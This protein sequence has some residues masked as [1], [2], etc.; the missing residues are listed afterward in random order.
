MPFRVM[1]TLQWSPAMQ[2][3]YNDQV[4]GPVIDHKFTD[5]KR[6]LWLGYPIDVIARRIILKGRADFGNGYDDPNHP[7]KPAEKT[8][9]YCFCNMRLHFFEALATF[10]RYRTTIKSMFAD[11][12]KTMMI[13][14]GCGPGT[15]GLALGEFM[16]GSMFSYV[17]LDIARPMRDKARSLL[18][19]GIDE[20]I[21]ANETGIAISRSWRELLKG[22]S[23]IKAQNVIV[24]ATYLFASESLNVDDVCSLV[25]ALCKRPEIERVVFIYSNTI[26]ARASK[27]YEEF[28]TKMDGGFDDSGLKQDEVEFI[29]D[30]NSNYTKKAQYVRERLQFKGV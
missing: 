25:R 18:Q 2:K 10:R 7:L 1:Q 6:Y 16:K 28:K 9:L 13:D 23:K 27:K 5:G 8:L 30:L 15:A 12:K 29:K 22:V 20:G 19:A 11:G 21:L 14:L 26:D 24:N 4:V 3:L 17:G